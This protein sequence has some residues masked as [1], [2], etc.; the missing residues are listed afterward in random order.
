MTCIG[1]L[2]QSRT[3]PYRK[4]DA[5]IAQAKTDMFTI[6]PADGKGVPG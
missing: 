4:D 1:D 5:R 2:I 6:L 3:V